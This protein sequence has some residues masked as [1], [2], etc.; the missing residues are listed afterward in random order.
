MSLFLIEKR[1]GTI[2]IDRGYITTGQLIETMSIQHREALSRAK[3]RSLGQ[4]LL[5]L[6][7]LNATQIHVVLDQM[8][9]PPAL[10]RLMIAGKHQEALPAA[11]EADRHLPLGDINHE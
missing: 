8:G 7:Y 11:L 1:F 4:I 2:A 5:D 3:H 9:L 10:F 6:G